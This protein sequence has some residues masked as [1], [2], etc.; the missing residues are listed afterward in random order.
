[1]LFSIVT[2]K[3]KIKVIVYHKWI[4]GSIHR[5]QISRINKDKLTENL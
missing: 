3:F 4:W 2:L 1:M 5:I